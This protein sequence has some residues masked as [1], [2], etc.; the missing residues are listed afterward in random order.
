MNAT[1][2]QVE[3]QHHRNSNGRYAR[4]NACELCGKSAGVDYYSD[5]RCNATGIGLVLHRSCADRLASM[6]DEQYAAALR[7]E[8]T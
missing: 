1:R 3:R 7:P 5:E 6:N 2:K 4:M 8:A